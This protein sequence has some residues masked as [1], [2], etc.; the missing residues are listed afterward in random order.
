MRGVFLVGPPGAGKTTQGERLAAALGGVHLSMG[1]LVRRWRA[2]GVPVPSP[3]ADGSTA[4][5]RTLALLR[6]AMSSTE[7]LVLDGFP[8]TPA[9]AA[10]LPE[11]AP[12]GV[13]LVELRAP[14]GACIARMKG[15]GRAGE[16]MA[17]IA[18]R[19]DTYDHQAPALRAAAAALGAP[20]LVV[21][22]EGSVDEVASAVR[23]ALADAGL[24][25]QR[26]GA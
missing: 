21:E 1:E 26:L 23:A 25:G 19:H 9:Q 12:A 4:R 24:A 10:W 11:I 20:V 7:L 3:R 2:E 16:D 15:R 17:T 6:Q 18:L 22:G 14:L 8:R 13:T 5:D